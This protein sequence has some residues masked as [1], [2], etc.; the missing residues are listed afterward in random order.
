MDFDLLYQ[1]ILDALAAGG[2]A[3]ITKSAYE[4]IQAPI[5]LTDA[6]F[7]VLGIAPKTC[8]G[9]WVWDTML[10][11]GHAPEEMILSFYQERYMETASKNTDISWVDWGP[12]ADQ[13]RL[14]KAIK[15]N[16]NIEGYAA[17]VCTHE[18]D[19]PAFGKALKILV[20]AAEIEMSKN[21]SINISGNPLVKVFI[22][23]LFNDLVQS[24][25]QL[26][27][28][29]DNLNTSFNGDYQIIG[30]RAQTSGNQGMLKY[31]NSSLNAMFPKFLTIIIEDTLFILL[32]SLPETN[33]EADINN[34]LTMLLSS[35][36]VYC[37]ISMHFSGIS[38]VTEHRRQVEKLL[39]IGPKL[40][41][42]KKIFFYTDFL[43]DSILSVPLEHME[44]SA[45]TAPEITFLKNFD[46]KNGTEYLPTLKMYVESI[47]NSA[48]T[49]KKLHI[50]RNTL[51]YRVKKIEK[52]VKTDLSDPD[53]YV[54]FLLYFRLTDLKKR[55]LNG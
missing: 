48:E 32:Y 54:K 6:S 53:I 1:Q 51:L 22:R 20:K 19:R 37:G 43:T 21:I 36:Q 12:V 38:K 49:A 47:E 15:I 41:S 4:V 52:I 30:V 18:K 5:I 31:I 44:I 40:S 7:K 34:K 29:E 11:E 8:L 28:W 9:D 13:P 3:T 14:M 33:S 39:T 17:I 24:P 23:N 27:L 26:K 16:H 25:E 45:C 50:H 35:F 10:K 42:E 55:L 2:V 46:K